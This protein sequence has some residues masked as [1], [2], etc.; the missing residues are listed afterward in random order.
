MH[1]DAEL[2]SRFRADRQRLYAVRPPAHHDLRHHCDA[3]A[4]ADHADDRF[5]VHMAG[6]DIRLHL[7]GTQ[8]SVHVDV[9][10][11]V[12]HQE[13]FSVEFLDGEGLFAVGGIVL[14]QDGVHRVVVERCPVAVDVAL[15]RGKDDVRAP[16]LEQLKGFEF[17]VHHAKIHVGLRTHAAEAVQNFR[18][19][20]HGKARISGDSDRRRPLL[21]DGLD[22][23]F[24]LRRRAEVF[25]DR[26]QQRLPVLCQR[27]TAVVAPDELHADLALQ[28]VDEVRQ[29]RLCVAH[30][31]RRFGK[32]AEVDGGHQNFKF[33]AVHI[34]TPIKGILI[35]NIPIITER[36]SFSSAGCNIFNTKEL[37]IP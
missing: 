31:L 4:L 2:P 13:F 34:P 16:L 22:L 37:I 11:P 27:N 1:T 29:P 33:F 12:G 18:H 6:A 9:E 25:A 26:G 24:E 28:T 7:F 23:V 15:P 36:F 19:P 8:R 35:C 3:K 5:I 30:D 10:A 17:V 32:A 14:R 20:V 21:R